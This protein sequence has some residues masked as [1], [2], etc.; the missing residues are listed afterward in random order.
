MVARNR[1]RIP[2]CRLYGRGFNSFAFLKTI[3]P[4]YTDRMP[5][6]DP[7]K[8]R[9]AAKLWARRNRAN[10]NYHRSEH[11]R[12]LRVMVDLYKTCHPCVDCG[13]AD[14]IV[15]EFDHVRGEKVANVGTMVGVG[16][17]VQAV[18]DEI[19]KC[20]VRC[21]NCHRRKTRMAAKS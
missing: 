21:A 1:C 3:E 13:E 19:A 17:A 7:D 20:D 2:G 4:C 8:Q 6:K 11:R 5:Y 12:K 18:L 14:P 16:R 15:L 10:T 9:T